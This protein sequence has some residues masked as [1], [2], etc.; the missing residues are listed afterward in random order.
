MLVSLFNILSADPDLMIMFS[1]NNNSCKAKSCYNEL[2]V[3]KR[4]IDNFGALVSEKIIHEKRGCNDR[5]SG[6]SF[7]SRLWSSDWLID[8]FKVAKFNQLH[9][10]S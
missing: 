8:K 6:I 3:D 4:I 1:R 5:I 9:V 7:Q 10:Q 2:H